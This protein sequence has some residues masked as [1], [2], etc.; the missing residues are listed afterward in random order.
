MY[1]PYIMANIRGIPRI[2]STGVT[3]TATEITYNFRPDASFGNR[4][5][6][7]VIVKLPTQPAGTTTT[8]SV[9]FSSGSSSVQLTN[10]GGVN[11]TATDVAL[12]GIYLVF[13]D[14]NNGQLQLL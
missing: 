10:L 13:Y 12:S 14:S 7:L 5:A 8:L 1:N 2:E 6:G 4:F 9:K 3:V 11:T